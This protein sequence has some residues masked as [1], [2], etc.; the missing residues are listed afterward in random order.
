LATLLIAIIAVASTAAI[1]F[2]NNCCC[3]T[4]CPMKR[5]AQMHCGGGKS[6]TIASPAVTVTIADAILARPLQQTAPRAQ[7]IVFA[8]AVD[9]RI[10]YERPPDTPPPRA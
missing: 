9:G 2:Q 1:P 5:A 6:C 10:A 8:S 4:S 7:E 3:K